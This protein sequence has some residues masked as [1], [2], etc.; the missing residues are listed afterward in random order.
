M[1]FPAAL[2]SRRLEKSLVVST[3]P[4]FRSGEF[5]FTRSCVCVCIEFAFCRSA[6]LPRSF[7]SPVHCAPQDSVRIFKDIRAKKALGMHYGWDQRHFDYFLWSMAKRH[8]FLGGYL[9]RG[10]WPLRK[11]PSH[12]GDLRKNVRKLASRTVRLVSVVSVKL[13]QF[14]QGVLPS[15]FVYSVSERIVSLVRLLLPTWWVPHLGQLTRCILILSTIFNLIYLIMF[16]TVPRHDGP[17]LRTW[18]EGR[19]QRRVVACISCSFRA[20]RCYKNWRV[21]SSAEPGGL[22][23]LRVWTPV[24]G[25]LKMSA[26]GSRVAR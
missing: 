1:K 22:V 9:G 12:L 3:L 15:I 13:W 20:I 26:R 23:V 7:T 4:W 16:P 8:N 5:N 24:K 21:E 25:S 18:Q 19:I 6:Y 11:W 10:R 2:R 17:H 14:D